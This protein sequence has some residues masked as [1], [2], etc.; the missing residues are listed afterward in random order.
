MWVIEIDGSLDSKERQ[1]LA[2]SI[3]EVLTENITSDSSTVLNYGVISDDL[4]SNDINDTTLD[5]F[6]WL[7]MLAIIVVVFVLAIVFRSALMIAAPLLGLTAALVW[8]Y[9]TITL[10]GRPFSILEVAV[11]P[12][13]FGL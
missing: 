7:L 1:N 11:A 9:G 8:T 2:K 3:R 10:L 4:I 13:V 6:T 5:N 12:V